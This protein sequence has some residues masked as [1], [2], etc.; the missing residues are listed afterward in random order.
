M[1]VHLLGIDAVSKVVDAVTS[2][3]HDYVVVIR[4][5]SYQSHV[6]SDKRGF[7]VDVH[8]SEDYDE[9]CDEQRGYEDKKS[10]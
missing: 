6:T 2:K 5:D 1:R 7:I 9:M 10:D 8:Y 4:T 3:T